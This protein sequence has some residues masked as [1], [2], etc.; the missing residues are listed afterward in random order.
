MTLGLDDGCEARR[1]G[2]DHS[3]I[4]CSGGDRLGERVKGLRYH[5]G[6]FRSRSHV[7]RLL[8]PL[9]AAFL[10]GACSHAQSNHAET[11]SEVGGVHE[12]VQGDELV[13][14]FDLNGDG[15]ADAYEHYKRTKDADGKPVD[16]LVSKEFDL[17][18][19]GKVDRQLFYNDREELEREADDTN[20]DGKVDVVSYYQ[21]GQVVR[22]ERDLDAEG[23]PHTWVYYDRGHIERKER[24]LLRHGKPDYWEYWENG[25]I[26]RIG[27]DKNGD[28]V[29]DLWEKNPETQ[30]K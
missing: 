23:K 30:G 10:L 18:F 7:R 4:T 11:I 2:F 17:N 14:S 20:F 21:R 26:D 19:D 13:K 28:G 8:N 3:L 22:T 5:A 1:N 25:V 6:R 9:V 29:I 27:Y 24:D 15:K 16:R 12:V